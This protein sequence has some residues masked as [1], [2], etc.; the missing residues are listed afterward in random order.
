MLGEHEWKHKK[1][2]ICLNLSKEAWLD[3]SFCRIGM[4]DNVDRRV[5]RHARE[6]TIRIV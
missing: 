5:F 1:T 6:V 3:G 4:V 2:F